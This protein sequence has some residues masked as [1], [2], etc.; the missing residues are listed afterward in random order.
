MFSSLLFFT[1]VLVNT[2]LILY[3]LL[4]ALAGATVELGKSLRRCRL[5]L[6]CRLDESRE[7]ALRRRCLQM[8]WQTMRLIF[9]LSAIAIAYLPSLVFAYYRSEPSAA[10]VS[11]EALAGMAVAAVGTLL[12]RRRA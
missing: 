11:I 3:Y 8:S 4:P 5:Y 12:L 9:V 2:G 10:F 7:I 6:A 1:C